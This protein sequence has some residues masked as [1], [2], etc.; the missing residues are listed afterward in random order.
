MPSRV[1]S[2]SLSCLTHLNCLV[3]Q[4]KSRCSQ[5]GLCCSCCWPRRYSPSRLPH[6]SQ[7]TCSGLTWLSWPKKRGQPR[8]CT[9]PAV[10]I[11]VVA[12]PSH[13][14]WVTTATA[15]MVRAMS[16]CPRMLCTLIVTASPLL[17]CDT[18]RA[19]IVH[20]YCITSTHCQHAG[21][22]CMLKC[23]QNALV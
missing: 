23:A 13:T 5:P 20:N 22:K 10:H 19:C 4:S 11:A 21:V 12:S 6:P 17:K 2:A 1:G 3:A 9:H 8:R 16:C 15:A 18:G 14:A 7:Y